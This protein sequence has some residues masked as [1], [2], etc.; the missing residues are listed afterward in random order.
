MPGITQFRVVGGVPA[1]LH[2]HPWIAALAYS[3]GQVKCGGTL[4]TARHVITAA[5]CVND[6]LSTVILGE[7]NLKQDQDKA[8]PQTFN[9]VNVTKHGE[10]NKRTQD[11]DIAIIKLD[12]EVIFNVGIRPACL[13]SRED[14]LRDDK[15]TGT[16]RA[17]NSKQFSL[18]S[19]KTLRLLWQ[20]GELSSSEDQRLNV[21]W[22]EPSRS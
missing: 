6:Q 14:N 21:S 22:K 20:V 15:V 17:Q 12:R 16:L 4:V 11:N 7:H 1:R 8:S 3:D 19:L 2:A 18:S 9:I 10:Y 13:P 5:H